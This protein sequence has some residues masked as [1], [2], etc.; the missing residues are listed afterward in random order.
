MEAF[1]A[2]LLTGVLYIGWALVRVS[3]ALKAIEVELASARWERAQIERCRLGLKEQ[4]E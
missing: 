4:R 3:T 1:E 2:G